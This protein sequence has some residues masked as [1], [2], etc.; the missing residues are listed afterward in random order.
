MEAPQNDLG[1]LVDAEGRNY[2]EKKTPLLA[3]WLL[4]ATTEFAS[5]YY[6]A[7]VLLNK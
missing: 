5:N 6:S 4:W 7:S 2:R 3:T 1:F